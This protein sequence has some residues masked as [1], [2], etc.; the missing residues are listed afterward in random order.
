MLEL[1]ESKD[2]SNKK[3]DRIDVTFGTCQ[4]CHVSHS[5]LIFFFYFEQAGVNSQGVIQYINHNIYSDNG[6]IVNEPLIMLGV[7]LFNNCYKKDLFN[8]KVYN[9]VTDTPS[10][11]WCRAPG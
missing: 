3:R 9:V 7:G 11:S 6:C 2:Q 8:Y 4:M 5:S 1:L 10:N